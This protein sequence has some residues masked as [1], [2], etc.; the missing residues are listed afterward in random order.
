MVELERDYTFLINKLPDD[1]DEFPSRIRRNDDKL[2][3]LG[4]IVFA[5]LAIALKYGNSLFV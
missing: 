1:L 2:V 3:I 5:V 4:F